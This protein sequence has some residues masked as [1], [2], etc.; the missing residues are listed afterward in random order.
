MG[1]IEDDSQ[2]FVIFEEATNIMLSFQLRKFFAWFI[3][4]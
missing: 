4:A 1:L 2:I 3:L